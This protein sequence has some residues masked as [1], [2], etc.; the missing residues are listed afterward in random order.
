MSLCLAAV[1]CSRKKN[2]FVFFNFLK[3]DN[4]NDG[5]PIFG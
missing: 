1:G 5:L 4:V 3:K 2:L